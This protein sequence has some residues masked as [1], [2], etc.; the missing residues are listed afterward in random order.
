L[1]LE[2]DFPS[3]IHSQQHSSVKSEFGYFA[4]G[5]F[6]IVAWYIPQQQA[7]F[8]SINSTKFKT[9]MMAL[10]MLLLMFCKKI[11]EFIGLIF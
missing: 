10:L 5:C 7:A 2:G 1:F 9:L 11:S 3:S 6:T 4:D 8:N